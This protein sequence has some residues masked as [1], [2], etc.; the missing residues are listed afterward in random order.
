MDDHEDIIEYIRSLDSVNGRTV[1]E[2]LGNDIP[3][4]QHMK[5]NALWTIWMD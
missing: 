3:D 5:N 4:Y 1:Q 2:N